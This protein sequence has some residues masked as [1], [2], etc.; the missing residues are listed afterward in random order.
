MAFVTGAGGFIG[1]HAV[2]ALR[3][4]GWRTAGLSNR[5]PPDDGLGLLPADAWI[6]GSIDA[7]GLQR[8]LAELGSPEVIIHAAGGSSVGAAKQDPARDHLRT[9]GSVEEV[10]AFMAGSAPRARLLFLSSAAVYGDAGR[11]QQG[12]LD[13]AT[14]APPV[15]V[16]GGHKQEAEEKIRAAHR[17]HGLDAVAVRFFSVYGEGLGKQIFWDLTKRLAAD[18]TDFKLGGTGK[19]VRDFLHVT[20]AVDFLVRLAAAPAGVLPDR[21]NG[22]AGRETTVR[23]AAEALARALGVDEVPRFDNRDR[24]DNPAR[25]VADPERA[26]KFGLQPRIGLD[27]GLARFVAWARPQLERE[28]G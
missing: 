14:S 26:L 6:P 11:G 22:G 8:A 21:I 17:D 18:P 13:E 28:H 12:G 24:S 27:E 1:R 2:S 25:L 19:E 20:D 7:D 23:E 5:A 15:S 10:L 16:Y 9:V 3:N 4:A